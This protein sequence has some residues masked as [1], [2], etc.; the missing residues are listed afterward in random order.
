MLSPEDRKGVKELREKLVA[1]ILGG[2]SEAYVDCYEGDGIVMHPGS[3]P[4]QGHSAIREHIGP[5]FSAVRVTKFLLSPIV[6]EGSSDLAYDAGTQELETEPA[7]QGFGSRRKYLHVMRR[8]P[9]NTWR[10][11]VGTSSD[12]G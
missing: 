11:L 1:A 4:I 10:L 9:N 2:D 5:M 7:I 8:Q 3:P 6:I 12:N